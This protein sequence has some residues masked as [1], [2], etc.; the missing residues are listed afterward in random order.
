ML[1]R[2]KQAV[3]DVSGAQALPPVGERVGQLVEADARATTP[4]QK[5]EAHAKELQN[6]ATITSEMGQGLK[7]KI[8]DGLSVRSSKEAEH[9][10]V[11]AECAV[12]MLNASLSNL[13]KVVTATTAACPPTSSSKAAT[14]VGSFAVR[15]IALR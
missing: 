3:V 8:A 12:A 7:Q 15:R 10:L 1:R 2:Y 11:V 13:P 9:A 6:Y 5:A 4:W 14:S